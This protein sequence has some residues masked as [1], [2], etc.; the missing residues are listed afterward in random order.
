M[1]LFV[2]TSLAEEQRHHLRQQLPADV[3]ATFR[4]EL[5]DDKPPTAF[6]QADFLLGN[7]PAAWFA[8][9]VTPTLQFWQ[10]DSAGFDQY[11]GLTVA[12]PVANMGDYFAWPCAESIVAGILG[13]YRHIPELAVLQDRK[14]W[15]GAPV[16]KKLGLLRGKKTIILGTG[17]IGL[18]VQQQLAGFQCDV[19]LLART[20]S[21]AQLHSK[22]E[23]QAALPAAEL[24][25]NCL[26]GS[27]DQFFSAELIE[28]MAPGS[29]YASIGRGNTT[30]EPALI[31][32]LQA[33]KIGG[34]VLDVTAEEPLPASSPLWD[35]PTV[36]LT[37]HTGGGLPEE[38]AG[39][40]GQ[41][42]RNLHH[43][44]QG[45]ALE[46]VIDLTKGY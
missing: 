9:G 32:A 35:M 4:T 2:Y 34:A 15:V 12:C 41:F 25:V 46:N 7:P 33:G 18:A 16:R 13:W 5:T 20:D 10:I 21:R 39:K 11:A 1:R 42:L 23:L 30:D 40:T 36:L 22:A 17:A 28:A 24:V 26:P 29:V 3:E 27:A 44:R 19:Q 45:E 31:A 37:Q 6:Q 8:A 43:F 14:E 38:E